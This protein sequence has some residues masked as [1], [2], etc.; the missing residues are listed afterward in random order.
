MMKCTVKNIQMDMS[1]S[2]TNDILKIFFGK[3]LPSSISWLHQHVISNTK[4]QKTCILYDFKH[5]KDQTT[6]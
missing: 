3:N 5:T 1:E 4:M 2:H 6:T